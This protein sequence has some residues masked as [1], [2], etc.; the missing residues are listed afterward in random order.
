MASVLW[1]AAA[2]LSALPPVVWAIPLRF[3]V[4]AAKA[5]FE[6]D[7]TFGGHLD[8]QA[9]PEDVERAAGDQFAFGVDQ[10]Q[11]DLL[12]ALGVEFFTRARCDRGARASL[13]SKQSNAFRAA[14]MRWHALGPSASNDAR[15]SHLDGAHQYP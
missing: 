9:L 13:P 10:H 3:M 12:L 11:A 14:R 1:P 8:H 2:S 15:Q 4:T 5:P 6:D 7:D